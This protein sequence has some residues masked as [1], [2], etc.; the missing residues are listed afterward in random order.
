MHLWLFCLRVLHWLGTSPWGPPSLGTRITNEPLHLVWFFFSNLFIFVCV[1]V[2]VCASRWVT[3]NEH[4]IQRTF[5][6][7]WVAGIKLRESSS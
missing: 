2:S 4:A 6:G 5:G 3:Q 7:Q 1:N